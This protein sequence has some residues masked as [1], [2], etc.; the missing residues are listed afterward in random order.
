MTMPLFDRKTLFLRI[1]DWDGGGMSMSTLLWQMGGSRKKGDPYGWSQE[2][3]RAA[4][5][6]LFDE[7]S[8]RGPDPFGRY[9]P[10]DEGRRK[11]EARA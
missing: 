10:T 3:I 7:G 9:W 8:L 1:C 6:A 4:F 5:C 11:Y 2:R